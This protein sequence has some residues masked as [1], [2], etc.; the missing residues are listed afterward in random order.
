MKYTGDLSKPIVRARLVPLATDAEIGQESG[1]LASA[2]ADKMPLLFAAYGIE[3]G[4]YAALAMALATAHVPGFNVIAPA[5]RSKEWTGYDK[6]AFKLDIDEAKA[7]A[8]AKG[9]PI[10]LAVAIKL[11]MQL[12]EWKPRAE[13]ARAS[14]GEVKISSL[15]QHYY[16]AGQPTDAARAWLHIAESAKKAESH[17]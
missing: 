10:S 14:K 5:G 15:E 11:V 7:K 17:S 12:D 3:V 4:N 13:K 9:K 1:R 16:A 2:L 6:A 8:Q